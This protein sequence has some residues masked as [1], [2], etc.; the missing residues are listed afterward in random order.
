VI[1]DNAQQLQFSPEF[2]RALIYRNDR[3]ASPPLLHVKLT[4]KMHVFTNL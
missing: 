2:L 3:V 4:E 1:F